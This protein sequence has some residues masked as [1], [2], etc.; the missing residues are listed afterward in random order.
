MCPV[1][2]RR[3][4]WRQSRRRRWPFVIDVCS[5]KK[6]RI[7]PQLFLRIFPQLFFGFVIAQLFL[8]VRKPQFIWR[9]IPFK[10]L[11]FRPFTQRRVFVPPASERFCQPWRRVF[12]PSAS[13]R[14]HDPRKRRCTA[15]TSEQRSAC[16]P[17]QRPQRHL[18]SFPRLRKPASFPFT[19]ICPSR[20]RS[21]RPERSASAQPHSF[22][23]TGSGY[24]AFVC[25]RSAAAC[26]AP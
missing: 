24:P 15:G 19:G 12:F 6:R 4:P 21:P 17:E 5:L 10:R 16:S 20:R 11:F 14:F 26:P 1:P 22:R 2:W 8:P 13:E 25:R 23:Q 9:N 3:L 7:F 18:G